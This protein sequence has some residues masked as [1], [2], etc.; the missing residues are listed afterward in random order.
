MDCKNPVAD[1][2]AAMIHDN[3]LGKSMAPVCLGD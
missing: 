3:L 1:L 2:L